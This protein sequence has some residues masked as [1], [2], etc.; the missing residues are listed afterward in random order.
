[1]PFPPASCSSLSPAASRRTAIA[2]IAGVAGVGL[3]VLRADAQLDG[4]GIVAAVGGAAVMATGVVLS[5]RWRSP[6]PLLATTGW[7]LVAGGCCSRS[8]S[9]SKDRRPRR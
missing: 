9:S 6:V 5:K 7:Q 1:M 3:L 8:P 4:F 2:G